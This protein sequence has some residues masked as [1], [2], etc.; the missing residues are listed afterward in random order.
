MN[1][2]NTTDVN[3][4]NDKP[5]VVNSDDLLEELNLDSTAENKTVMA[6]LIQSSQ[7]LIIDAVN[8]NLSASKLASDQ[9]YIRAVKALATTLYFDRTL[10]QGYPLGVQMMITHLKGRYAKWQ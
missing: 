3:V 2:D 6:A 8:G 7:E 10:S 9:I 5:L 4:D 1:N